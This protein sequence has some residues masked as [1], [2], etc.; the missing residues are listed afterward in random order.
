MSGGVAVRGPSISGLQALHPLRPPLG[1]T[2]ST[3]KGRRQAPAAGWAARRAAARSIFHACGAGLP[4][5]P[6]R[7]SPL[8]SGST[9]VG[10]AASPAPRAPLQFVLVDALPGAP[11][12]L[13]I[14]DRD[15]GRFAVRGAADG[16]LPPPGRG[17]SVRR[18]RRPS[19]CLPALPRTKLS[20]H[21]P[22]ALQNLLGLA[23]AVLFV[24]YNYVTA[25]KQE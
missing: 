7:P 19:A 5:R 3:V 20:P 8:F 22:P 17:G 12:S 1:R 10:S 2:Y 9:F 14:D 24:A 18:H 25:K 6:G 21:C 11:G 16:L 4:E 13:M 15:L 23:I